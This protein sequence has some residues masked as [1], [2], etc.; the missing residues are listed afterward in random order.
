MT[1]HKNSR[2]DYGMPNENIKIHGRFLR[3]LKN[4][5][6][7]IGCALNPKIRVI[8][9]QALLT[10]ELQNIYLYICIK[11][12]STYN[13][14]CATV[15]QITSQGYEIWDMSMSIRRIIRRIRETHLRVRYSPTKVMLQSEC[16][17]SFIQEMH[18]PSMHFMNTTDTL[19]LSLPTPV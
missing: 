18:L 6:L 19:G 3:M 14:R 16:H 1:Y 13:S 7:Y 8:E 15:I 11:S 17:F 12:L 4:A 10:N 5:H 2:G 9:I